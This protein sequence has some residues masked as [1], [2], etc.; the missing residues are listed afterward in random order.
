MTT[1]MK[2]AYTT[3]SADI[4]A[5]GFSTLASAAVHTSNAVDNSANLYQDY[6]IEVNAGGTAAATSFLDVRMAV[7][8]DGTNYG[9]WESAIPLGIIDFSVQPQKAHFSLVGHG[10]LF[11]APQRFKIMVKNNSGAA[12]TSGTIYW[13]GIQI[14]SV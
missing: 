4:A 3:M 1:T 14:Q 13:Q 7:C 9:T 10:G 8:E 6:L 12:L 11:Q 5:A 2:P